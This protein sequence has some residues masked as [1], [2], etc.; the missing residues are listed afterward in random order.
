ML[1]IKNHPYHLL[2]LTAILFIIATQFL[3][4]NSTT[5]IS[6]HDSYT[7][8]STTYFIWY[9]VLLLAI[10]WVL[11]VITK[12]I[13]YS[14]KLSWVHT[15]FTIF[16]AL[17]IVVLPY[18]LPVSYLALTGMPRR[19]YTSVDIQ[20]PLEQLNYMITIAFVIAIAG[21][22]IYFINLAIGL[23]FRWKRVSK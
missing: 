8:L 7:L 23:W 9:A 15:L 19:Y 12:N 16:T 3:P 14:N 21:Q 1:K 11:Y 17:S 18:V 6:L 13:L 4:I 10:F 5:D 22:F 20:E 2:L